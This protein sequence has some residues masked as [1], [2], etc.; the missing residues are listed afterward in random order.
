M[1]Q[2]LVVAGEPSGDDL[3]SD[4]VGEI[5][6]SAWGLG[7]P[8]LAT[9]GLDAIAGLPGVMGVAGIAWQLP[10]L[11]RLHRDLL[12]EAA[13]RKPQAALLVGFSEFNGR[14]AKSLGGLGIPVVWYAPPQ[15]WVWRL[16]RAA[17]L[18]TRATAFAT[19]FRSETALWTNAGA[20][21]IH[22]G[23]PAAGIQPRRCVA[24]SSVPAP[25]S[26]CKS[27]VLLPGSRAKEV[28]KHI[29]PLVAATRLLVRSGGVDS[30]ALFLATNLP[31]RLKAR[32]RRL[33]AWN[34]IAVFSGPA[35]P[36]LT[37]FDA[38]IC[39]SGTA[40]LECAMA[41][42]PAVIVYDAG[43]FTSVVAHRLLRV[44]HIGLPNLLL[45]ER[46][47]PEL[48]GSEVRG[49]LIAH[50]IRYQLPSPTRIRTARLKLLDELCPPAATADQANTPCQRVAELLRPWLR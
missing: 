20:R 11:L 36:S 34:G 46:V 15:V 42:V 50:A 19:L 40:T 49:E 8:R 16:G 23:H 38:A 25:G 33:C 24:S 44:P 14:L 9:V 31:S 29:R 13:S 32:V 6:C 12:N 7:G 26:S 35:A 18:A 4:V 27:L 30:I 21:A 45:N 22:V 39:C 5:G 28:A 17:Q 10:R 37:D 2:L 41:E 47:F 48:L 1:S 43:P 3:A